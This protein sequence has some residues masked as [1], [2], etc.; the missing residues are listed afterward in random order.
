MVKCGK[1]M[2]NVEKIDRGIFV[3]YWCENCKRI[4]LEKDILLI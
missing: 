2:E 1:C 4:I 3:E